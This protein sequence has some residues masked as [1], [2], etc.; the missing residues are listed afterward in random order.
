MNKRRKLFTNFLG[1]AELYSIF[2]E[3]TMWITDDGINIAGEI[4][5]FKGKLSEK[6]NFIIDSDIIEGLLKK[7]Q[8]AVDEIL[9][10]GER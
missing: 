2:D 4:I 7:Y 8:K 3:Y 10:E 1:L 6:D 5:P 9:D